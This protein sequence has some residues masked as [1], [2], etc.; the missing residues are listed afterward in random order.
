MIYCSYDHL[1][2]TVNRET[3]ETEHVCTA[4]NSQKCPNCPSRFNGEK[5]KKYMEEHPKHSN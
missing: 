5:I 1:N 2:P 3:G 4:Y